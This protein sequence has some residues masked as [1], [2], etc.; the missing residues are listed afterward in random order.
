MFVFALLCCVVLLVHLK[1]KGK[2]PVHTS[3]NLE[4]QEK[5]RKI[6]KLLAHLRILEAL[7]SNFASQ[8]SCTSR[9]MPGQYLKLDHHRFPP[10][11]FQFIIH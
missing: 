8:T 10:Y 4:S 7:G 1:V 6:K 3:N 9:Q 11:A 2:K 5:E